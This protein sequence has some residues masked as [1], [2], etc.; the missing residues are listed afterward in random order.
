MTT[1]EAALARV[2]EAIRR[3]RRFVV[4]S[5]VRPDGDAVGSALAMAFALRHLGKEARVVSRDPAPPPLLVFPGV[6]EIEI[7]DRVEDPGDAVIVME[8]GDLTRTGIAG[9]DRGFVIN[10]DHH[11]DNRMYGAVNWFDQ[12][13]AACGEMVFDLVG[14]LGVPLTYEIALHV[15]IAILTDTGSFHHSSISPRTFDICRQCVEAGVAPPA[16]AR[17]VYNNNNLGRLRLFGAVLSRMELDDSGR[18]ATMTVDQ[19]LT[20]DSGGTYDDT[21]G[22]INL[23]LTVKEIQAV[24][25][26]KENGPDDWRVSMRSKDAVDIN[27]VARQFGGGGH[28]NASGCSAAGRLDDLKRLFRQKVLEQI[29]LAGSQ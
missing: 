21:E 13:A 23:P 10:I 11:A 12:S 17:S 3:G 16:V 27:A 22:L 24:V 28:K 7:A 25:F 15:Y 2:V 20:A 18:L 14:A 5:H 19:R 1:S 9:L 26:F 8:S 6:R 4:T 29:E